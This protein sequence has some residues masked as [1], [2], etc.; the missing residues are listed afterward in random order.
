MPIGF[1]VSVDPAA[2]TGTGVKV[3][4]NAAGSGSQV[5]SIS[6]GTNEDL[7]L[8]GKGTGKVKLGATSTGDIEAH[9]DL[10]VQA[11]AL[12]HLLDVATLAAAGSEQGDAAA[13]TKQVTYVTASDGAKGVVLPAATAG[14]IYFVYNTVATSGLLIYPASGDDINDGS[15]NAAVTIEGKTM[16]VFVGMDTATWGAI[17][18][19]DT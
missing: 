13:I 16:A 18:T 8:D 19:A 14:A 1:E 6:S 11:G 10:K 12:L 9:Q 4:S 17:F 3:T 7:L 15:A 5:A 2:T